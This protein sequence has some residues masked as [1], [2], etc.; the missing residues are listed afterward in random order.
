MAKE[1]GIG[2]AFHQLFVVSWPFLVENGS[3]TLEIRSGS[4]SNYFVKSFA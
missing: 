1:I 4:R 3:P 2:G